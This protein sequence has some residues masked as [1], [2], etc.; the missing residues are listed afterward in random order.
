MR[1]RLAEF[2]EADQP[3]VIHTLDY[4]ETLLKF[5]SVVLITSECRRR[6]RGDQL[7]KLTTVLHDAETGLRFSYPECI[8]IAN[9]VRTWA[10]TEAVMK[11]LDV[12]RLFMEGLP[13]QASVDRAEPS[14]PGSAKTTASQEPIK[15]TASQ[16]CSL[17]A[18]SAVESSIPS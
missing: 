3:E 8:Y 5:G 6:D 15:G 10:S 2:D 17:I 1:D 7:P 16:A 9:E 12:I 4:Q 18:R 11:P 14:F 13:G